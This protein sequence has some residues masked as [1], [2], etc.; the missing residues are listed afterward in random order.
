MKQND[1]LVEIISLLFNKRKYII[2]TCTIAVIVA[3]VCS[4]IM[5]NYYS[6]STTFY[7]ASPDLAQPAPVGALERKSEYYGSDNDLDRLFSLANSNQIS[8]YLIEKYDLYNH[9]NINKEDKK[10]GFK[11]KE[12]F[13]KYFNTKKTKYEALELS[14]EDKDPELAATM[15]NDARNQLDMLAQ[16]VIKRSQ[17]QLIEKYKDNI[18]TKNK[19]LSILND[20]LSYIREKYGVYNTTSQSEI[21]TGLLANTQSAL[22]GY[23]AKY[24]VFR[25]DPIYR[26]SLTVIKAKVASSEQQLA[27]AKKQMSLFNEG[28]ANVVN[29]EIEQREFIEQ[30]SYD[31]ERYKQLVSA[32][33]SPFKALLVI[34]EA[35]VPVVKSR[36]K[37]SLYVI[38]AAILSFVMAALT[39]LLLHS[40]KDVSWKHDA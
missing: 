5:P 15:T 16:S 31:K 6:A 11:I 35:S 25:N 12:K 37:R 3:I 33:A 8:D 17:N 14:I 7:A 2:W 30:L 10:A 24:E 38:G 29:L 13:S 27:S 26:D 32:H 19:A 1:Q 21:L 18:A 28:L 40:F 4:L 23:K 34:E 20:S 36:P 22:S 39:I 9:Y